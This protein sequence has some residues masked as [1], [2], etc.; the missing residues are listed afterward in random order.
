MADNSGVVIPVS[1][2]AGGYP[3]HI[4]EG[5][6]DRLGELAGVLGPPSRAL[7]VTDSV[8]VGLYGRRCL[9]SLEKAGW[10][11]CDAVV[12]TGETAKTLDQAA[13]LYD[14]AVEAGLDRRSPVIALGGGVVGD[15][16][17]FVAA[18]YLR[19]VPLIQGP[20]TLLAQVDSSV[21]GKVAVN[22]PRGKNLIGA[23]YQPRLVAADPLALRTLPARQLQAGVAE[24][25]KYGLIGDRSF[26]TWLEGNLESLLAGDPAAVMHA[27][28]CSVR[29]KAAVVEKDEKEEDYRRVL[30]FGHTVGHALEAATGYKHYLHGEAVLVGM[31]AAVR[32]SR[33]MGLL[34]KNQAAAALELLAQVG[35][36]P[37]PPDLKVEVVLQAMRYDKKRIQERLVFVLLRSIGEA[38]FSDAVDADSVKK[39]VQ[40]GLLLSS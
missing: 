36:F 14:L 26:F 7:L 24:V 34:D 31:A 19:G 16:A 10:R 27:V 38:V 18:T 12:E 17:G 9:D 5:A 15:L 4:L 39:A 11:V 8:V 30:N 22:H 6:L 20:T 29:A 21:G 1:V 40:A 33:E 35:F 32:L 2:A 28:A 13:R 3:V 23:F 25:V 37:P